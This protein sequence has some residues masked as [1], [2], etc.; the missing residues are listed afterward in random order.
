MPWMSSTDTCVHT[1]EHALDVVAQLGE[2][3]VARAV[4]WDDVDLVPVAAGKF[5]E[6]VTR[7]H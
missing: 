4:V 1:L 2:R 5:K 3:V 6:V 7:I